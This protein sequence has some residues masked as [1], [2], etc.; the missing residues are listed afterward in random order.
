MDTLRPICMSLSKPSKLLV[1]SSKSPDQPSE[2]VMPVLASN[3]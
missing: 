3:P 1:N 2:T